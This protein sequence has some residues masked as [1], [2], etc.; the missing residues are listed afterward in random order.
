MRFKDFC[1][2]GSCSSVDG[3]DGGT[4]ERLWSHLND[5]DSVG[6]STLNI[7]LLHGIF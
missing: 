5:A 7:H 1:V 4:R 3:Q 6:L 2:F